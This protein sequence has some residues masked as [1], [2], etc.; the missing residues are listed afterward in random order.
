MANQKQESSAVTKLL[1]GPD[2]NN[3]EDLAVPGEKIEE[4]DQLRLWANMDRTLWSR[5]PNSRM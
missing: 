4:D 5:Q 1:E 2:Q 3:D